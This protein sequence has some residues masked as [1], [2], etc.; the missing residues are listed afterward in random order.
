MEGLA[1]P[2]LPDCNNGDCWLSGIPIN[3]KNMSTPVKEEIVKV[4]SHLRTNISFEFPK[5]F[6]PSMMRWAGRAGWPRGN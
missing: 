6:T 1:V 4:S 3:F 5:S 2:N